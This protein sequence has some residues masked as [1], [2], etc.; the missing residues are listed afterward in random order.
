MK[1]TKKAPSP[2]K[3]VKRGSNVV[4]KRSTAGL[5]LFAGKDYKKGE[6]IIEYTG[7]IISNDE[8]DRRGG[9]YLFVLT[10]ELIID[11]K[12][13][14]NRARYINHSCLPNSEPETD[15]D[16]QKIR[17]FAKHSIKSGDEITY[18]YGKAYFNEHIKPLGCRCKK[19]APH[20]YIYE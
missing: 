10:E 3:I 7:D 16:M 20:L 13:R 17:I 2:R 11:G 9:K 8:A 5:G 12:P 15:E 18:N 1:R 6:F 19:C 4:V 14:H